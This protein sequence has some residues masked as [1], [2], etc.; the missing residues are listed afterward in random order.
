MLESAFESDLRSDPIPARA[1][2]LQAASLVG[3]E[4]GVLRALRAADVLRASLDARDWLRVALDA[5]RARERRREGLVFGQG[6]WAAI[7]RGLAE[8]EL[9]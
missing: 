5:Q 4:S 1:I 9:G 2:G 8:E 6:A 7:A 3:V